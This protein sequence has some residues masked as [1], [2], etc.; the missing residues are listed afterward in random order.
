M[1]SLFTL[2]SGPAA[3][4][5][6]PHQA[7][8]TLSRADLTLAQAAAEQPGALITLALTSVTAY[9]IDLVADIAQELTRQ[10][11]LD[12][13]TL[14]RIE[15]ALSEAV[16]NALLHGNLALGSA[17]RNIG[18][19]EAHDDAIAQALADPVKAGRML[20]LAARR[21]DDGLDILLQDAGAGFDPTQSHD[22]ATG[23]SG[24]G[25]DL[26]QSLADRV[27]YQDGGRSICMSFR[28]QV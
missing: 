19:F 5:E 28:L 6:H 14:W 12:E 18:D 10:L 7:E 8:G 25:V 1:P 22:E 3:L 15:T 4:A 26:I 16:S 23:G 21:T 11:P 2:P 27:T 24:R 13:E 9:Q 20:L 17:A